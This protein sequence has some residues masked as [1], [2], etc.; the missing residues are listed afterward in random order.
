MLGEER[1]GPLIS[2]EYGCKRPAVLSGKL[3][4]GCKRPAVLSEKFYDGCKRPV[5]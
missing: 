4:D 5:V 2:L 1:R 3:C